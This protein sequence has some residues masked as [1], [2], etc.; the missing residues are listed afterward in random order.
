V[1]LRELHFARLVDYDFTAS[2]EEDLEDVASGGRLSLGS[3]FDDDLVRVGRW[4][5]PAAW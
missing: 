4:A 2:V 1:Q 5:V 3:L